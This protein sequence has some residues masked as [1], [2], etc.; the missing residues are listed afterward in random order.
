MSKISDW[1]RGVVT[2]VD[3]QEPIADKYVDD[4]ARKEN[5]ARILA[6][7]MVIFAIVIVVLAT[8]LL[9]A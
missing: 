4:L 8:N 9:A 6:W 2:R 5:T 3:K 7:G 1:W